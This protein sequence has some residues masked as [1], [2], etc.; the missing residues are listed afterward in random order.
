LYP[1]GLLILMLGVLLLVKEKKDVPEGDNDSSDEEEN[2][3]GA[4]TP[5]ERS[6]LETKSRHHE[7]VR[8]SKMM[9]IACNFVSDD[10]VSCTLA[11]TCISMHLHSLLR[12]AL[13][14]DGFWCSLEQ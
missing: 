8:T 4:S 5:E 6:E 7:L 13:Q 9:Q 14:C 12:S 1:T 3:T 10:P 11:Y 2:I